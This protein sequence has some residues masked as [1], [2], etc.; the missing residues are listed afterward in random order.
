MMRRE[1][2]KL[3]LH[4]K[5]HV[6]EILNILEKSKDF[7][8]SFIIDPNGRKPWRDEIQLCPTPCDRCEC[9]MRIRYDNYIFFILKVQNGMLLV[10]DSVQ[11]CIDQLVNIPSMVRNRKIEKII[12]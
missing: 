3:D 9:V 11:D 2:T 10:N 8:N 1:G 5:D 12:N 6:D 4:H 7:Y